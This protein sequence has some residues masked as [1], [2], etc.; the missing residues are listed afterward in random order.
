MRQERLLKNYWLL[1]AVKVPES[2][3]KIAVDVLDREQAA[4]ELKLLSKE[5]HYHDY[6]YYECDDPEISDSDYDSL[7]RRNLAIEERFPDLVRSDSP[8]K[9]VGVTPTS[10][11][12]KVT[13]LKPMLSLDNAFDE[14]DVKDFLARARRF[15]GLGESHAIEIFAEPKIDGLSCSLRYVNGKVSIAATRGDGQ[16]GE[17]VTENVKTLQQVPKELKGPAF[18][19]VIEIRGEIYI[20]HEDFNLLNKTR[21]GKGED[22]FANPRNAAAGSL[23]QLDPKI[24]AERPLK[25]FA[26]GFAS[27]PLGIQTHQEGIELLKAWGFP[28]PSLITLCHSFEEIIGYYQKLEEQRAYLPYDI[29][30]TVYKV[31]RLDFQERL[32]FVARAPRFALAH[33]FPPEQAQTTLNNIIIQV[34]RTGVLTPVALL[35]PVT[36]GGV[37]VGRA[38]LHNQDE[39]KR[40]DIRIG[41]KVV[42]QRAGDVIP[43][44]V[45][46]ID[47]DRKVRTPLF[48]FP[49]SCPSCG[50]KVVR[51][52]G[53]VALKC[54]GGLVCPSQA[55]LRLRH[56]VSRD[57]FDIEGLGARHVEAFYNEGLTKTPVDIFTFEERDRKS[58]TPLKNKEGWGP[59]SAQNLFSAI[60]KKREISLDRFIYSLGI[61]QVGQTTAKLLARNYGSYHHWCEAMVKATDVQSSA[62]QELISIEGIGPGVAADVITFF[63][64]DHNLKILQD[65]AGTKSSKGLVRIFNYEPP[66]YLESPLTGKIVVFTG[67]LKHSTRAEAKAKAENLGAKVAS[68]VS[69]KTDYVVVG[70]DPGSKAR[71]AQQL[72]VKILTEEEWQNLIKEF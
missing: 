11:F 32:G 49:S 69:S 1:E 39:I 22:L 35:E 58:L 21:E 26:Y 13:H 8:S 68:S 44:V 4:E 45:K 37:V 16:V 9:R 34:G 53:E 10:S 47:H 64:E 2:L 18:P 72:R 59:K 20:N 55:S 28:V 42:V 51:K 67:T 17:N 60:N 5:I 50:S 62:Y 40:K 12:A 61:S 66:S 23:R 6:R 52:E 57:A 15:L 71:E 33:K 56:F 38:T 70:V 25:F 29:D 36:I 54:T 48:E 31:N 14:E 41:D 7:R 30:G 27:Y 43:Q 46:V 63:S 19:D 3:R 65:L 24:T